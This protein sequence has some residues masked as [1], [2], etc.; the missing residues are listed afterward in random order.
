[1]KKVIFKVKLGNRDEF[2]EKMAGKGVDF[3]PIY[4]QHDRIYVPR[5]YRAGV[6]LPR[7]IMRTEMKAIDKPAK[8]FVILKRHIFDTNVEM[9]FKTEVKSY[10]EMVGIV[11]M[12]GFSL[13]TEVSRKRQEAK[14]PEGILYLDKVEGVSGF[15][16]KLEAEVKEGKRTESVRREIRDLLE[17]L[18][19]RGI[20]EKPYFQMI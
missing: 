14:L 16:A 17:T 8:Y 13:K 11:A 12:A 20:V 9:E 2:E 5:G 19:E 6:G 10:T 4:W 7:V 3:S 15:Y 1:M 18:G